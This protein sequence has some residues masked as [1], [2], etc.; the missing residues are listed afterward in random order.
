LD[1]RLLLFSHNDY[2]T[3]VDITGRIQR[4]DKR[5]SIENNCLPILKRLGIE[6]D[7]W[8]KSTQNFEMLFY[9]KFYYRRNE[10]NTA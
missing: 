4:R 3:L 7:D 9:S 6:A 1:H 2:L 5:G 10:R 8:I